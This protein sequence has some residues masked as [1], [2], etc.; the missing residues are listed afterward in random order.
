VELGTLER[1]APSSL[2]NWLDM[3]SPIKGASFNVSFARG[4]RLRD[5]L[6]IDAELRDA[7]QGSSP[8]LVA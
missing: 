5:E 7:A 2:W 1:V 8:A 3:P 6:Y 4:G